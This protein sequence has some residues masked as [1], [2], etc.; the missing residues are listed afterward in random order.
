M[1]TELP[2]A[3]EWVDD[4]PLMDVFMSQ[5]R[6][7][8]L[9]VA[10]K[11][12]VFA[13]LHDEPADAG[14]LAK[15]LEV[16]HD[17]LVAVLRMV[18]GLGFLV[19]HSGEF[20]LTQE[21]RWFLLPGVDRYWGPMI[22]MGWTETCTALHKTLVTGREVGYRGRDM[23]EVHERSRGHAQAFT[24]A[25]HAHSAAPATA[26]A[27]QLD[28]S[29]AKTLIDIGGG[30]GIYGIELVRRNPELRVTIMDLPHVL[31]VTEQTVR[32]AGLLDNFDLVAADMFGERWPGGFDRVLFTGV[33]GDWND[34]ACVDLAKRSKDSLAD[35][36]ELVVYQ[37][38]VDDSG[39]RPLAVAGHGVAMTILTDGRPRTAAD[40]GDVL[41]RAG[42]ADIRHKP[43]FGYYSL[44]IAR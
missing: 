25:M 7:P 30:S 19:E 15:R 34:E 11:L 41:R 24:R 12:G 3:V 29:G 14:V 1:S 6:F 28:L 21:A 2:P 23:W 36:G 37:M 13:A 9:A 40:L 18:A 42:F 32:E 20:H 33:L 8:A 38:L 22:R 39:C 43:S 26:L 17:G 16:D 4:R 27:G 35:G 31:E 10:D 44:F 5:Y